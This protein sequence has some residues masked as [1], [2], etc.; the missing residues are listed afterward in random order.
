LLPHWQRIYRL[1]GK[2]PPKHCP[3]RAP[4]DVDLVKPPSRVLS[5]LF[6]SHQAYHKP[7]DAPRILQSPDDLRLS[8]SKCGQ[9]RL[10]LNTLLEFAGYDTR[11]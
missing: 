6:A 4:E 7:R 3:W 10:F 8:A 9:L 2:T 1:A 5:D 11:L